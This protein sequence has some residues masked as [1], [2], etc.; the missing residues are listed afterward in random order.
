M[1]SRVLDVEGSDVDRR[2]I[3]LETIDVADL[4]R[5]LAKTYDM[6][7]RT[8]SITIIT[9][10]LDQQ[11]TL[12]SD[13]QLLERAIANLL[14]NAVKYSPPGGKI[15]LSVEA[16]NSQVLI[17]VRDEGPGISAEDQ[18]KIFSKYTQATSR[19]TGGEKSTGL[20]LFIV[21]RIM[22]E[23]QGEV[24]CTSTPGKGA[25]FTLRLRS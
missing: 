22:D 15:W 7:A 13:R 1:I 8:K 9:P 18:R 25:E 19:P 5:E 4:L 14:S 10:G 23:L 21:Q 20:G 6:D 2:R 3:Q 11:L 17:R 24:S 12:L 16:Q